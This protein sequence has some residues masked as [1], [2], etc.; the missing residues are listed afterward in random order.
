MEPLHEDSPI[1]KFLEKRGEGIHHI[2]FQVENIESEL[3]K[4]KN[5][6]IRL[7]DQK[8]RIGAYNSKVAFIHPKSANGVLVELAELQK[9]KN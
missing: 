2:C 6:G 5:I 7:I 8:P 3:E 9:E 4:L 1:T